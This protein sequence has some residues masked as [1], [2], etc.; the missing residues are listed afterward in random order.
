MINPA[1]REVKVIHARAYT[2]LVVEC[3]HLF[4]LIFTYLAWP[5][6]LA[7]VLPG[8]RVCVHISYA[9]NVPALR[10]RLVT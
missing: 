5:W 6:K 3:S 8:V 7:K 4:A 9:V 1:E 10:E 2:L